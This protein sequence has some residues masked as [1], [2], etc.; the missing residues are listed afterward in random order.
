MIDVPFEGQNLLNKTFLFRG[1]IADLLVKS[2][3]LSFQVLN[4]QVEVT[5]LGRYCLHRLV[6]LLNFHV[7]V[8]V[9]SQHV[10]LFNLDGSLG[11]EGASLAVGQLLVLSLENLVGMG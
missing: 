3:D 2:T 1:E 5:I 10:L 8:T 11:L 7:R 6:K 4:L 9:I